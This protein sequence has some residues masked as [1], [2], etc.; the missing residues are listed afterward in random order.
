MT[1][2]LRIAVE[3]DLPFVEAIVE[4]A[5]SHYIPI[6]GQKPGPMVDDYAALIGDRRVHVLQS[7]GVIKGVL[8]LIPEENAML[9]DNIA[10]IPAAK[11]AGLGREMLMFAE[12]SARDAGYKSIRLY[13]HE[14]MTQNIALYSRIGYVETHRGEEKG[15]RRVYMTKALD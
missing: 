9:L 5:Y 12:Q 7:D 15:L 8:V 11:G 1:D 6:I 10:V 3:E 13:T 2:G 4:A 14:K